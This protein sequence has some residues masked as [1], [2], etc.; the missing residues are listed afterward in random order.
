VQLVVVGFHRSGT[1][2]L[3]Q[4]LVEAG[5]FVGDDLLGSLPSN[6]YGHFEDREVLQIQRDILERHGHDWQ[7][8]VTFPFF[9]GEDHW[10]RM[11]RFA[12][13]RDLAHPLWGF[14]DPRTCLFLGAWKYLL[15]DA[16][17]VIVYRDPGECV[18]SLESRQAI[19][20]FESRGDAEAHLRFFREPDHGLR[21]WHT[22]NRAVVTFAS[23]HLDD[24]L[25][26]PF[27]ALTGGYPV[28][29]RVNQ[30][31]GTNL[32]PIPTDGVF[33]PRATSRRPAPQRVID[34]TVA[35]R[36]EQTWSDLEDLTRKTEAV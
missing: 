18:R 34:P 24:C 1:S 19:D 29:D 12:R 22:Y 9:I 27:T 5:L 14:K 26:L 15:P 10:H 23:G 35:S 6:P 33:D 20:L 4:L 30:R 36:V 3:T 32:P 13:R 2:L 28:I 16:K 17:F 11:R 21:L 25:V 31:F 8:D 7:W